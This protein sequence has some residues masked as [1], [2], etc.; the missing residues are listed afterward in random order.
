MG[1]GWP[2]WWHMH[3]LPSCGWRGFNVE[4]SEGRRLK[5]DTEDIIFWRQTVLWCNQSIACSVMTEK[6]TQWLISISANVEITTVIYF[7]PTL[8]RD[9]GTW[10]WTQQGTKSELIIRSWGA[11]IHEACTH[12]PRSS[13]DRSSMRIPHFPSSSSGSLQFLLSGDRNCLCRD[14]FNRFNLQYLIYF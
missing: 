4:I 5:I 1:L 13:D 9:R 6:R 3:G 10:L 14:P 7:R 8:K 11:S 12:W 2:S